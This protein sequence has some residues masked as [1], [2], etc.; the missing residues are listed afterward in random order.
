MEFFF[1]LFSCISPRHDDDGSY[2]HR[3]L[4]DSV[5]VGWVADDTTGSPINGGEAAELGQM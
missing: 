3:H 4:R 5:V 1:A 2:T